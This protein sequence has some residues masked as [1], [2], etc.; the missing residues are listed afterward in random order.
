MDEKKYYYMR[1]KENFFD[2]DS[3]K[4]LEAMPD[5]YLYSNIL[6]KMYLSS[7]KS[8]GRL[9]LNDLIPYNPQM[10]ASITR[11][12]VGTVEKALDVFQTMGLIEVLDNG[13]IYMLNIQNYIGKSSDV[14]DR[15]REYDRKIADEKKSSRNL[16]RNLEENQKKY[17]PE[18]E[19]EKEIEKEPEKEVSVNCQRIADMY[20]SIC[21]SLP[22]VQKLTS[23]RQNAI[24][25]ILKEYP[26]E[27]VK[28]VF[29]KVQASDF[30]TGKT[31]WNGC[32]FDWIFKASNF[33][34]I[35]EGN[36]DNRTK[37]SAPSKAG[38]DLNSF[39]N[40]A[41]GWANGDIHG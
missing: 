22:K 8:K 13:A 14:A 23:G 6:L 12:Q 38:E 32:G 36:Y 20:N 7:L 26:E 16:E 5:G 9:M 1:L 40:M 18:I 17:L 24:R 33:L 34:K 37:G 35:L 29:E 11:H 41:A 19:I 30:L 2:D 39:Y 28:A 27:T 4:I 25:L 10:I 21:K 3:M 15:Q 31:G